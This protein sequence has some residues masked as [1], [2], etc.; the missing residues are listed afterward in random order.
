VP[1]KVP[2]TGDDCGVRA[3]TGAV[4]HELIVMMPVFDQ[5]TST[6]FAFIS[7]M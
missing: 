7:A 3:I 1:W 5:E 6:K 4:H 2:E